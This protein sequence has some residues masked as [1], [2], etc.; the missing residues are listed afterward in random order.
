MTIIDNIFDD[1]DIKKQYDEIKHLNEVKKA[2]EIYLFH[3]YEK[4]NIILEIRN[5]YYDIVNRKQG[6]ITQDESKFQRFD[7][8]LLEYGGK[9]FDDKNMNYYFKRWTNKRLKRILKILNMELKNNGIFLNSK[10]NILEILK[11]LKE[12]FEMS[13]VENENESLNNLITLFNNLIRNLNE[14]LNYFQNIYPIKNW[15]LENHSSIIDNRI[16]NLISVEVKLVFDKNISSDYFNN[17]PGIISRAIHEMNIPTNTE[18]NKLINLHIQK[19]KSKKGNSKI[20]FV[21]CYHA[22]PIQILKPVFPLSTREKSTGFYVDLDM[23]EA[24]E[25]IKAI[26]GVNEAN[27]EVYELE[28][29]NNLF[30]LTN[31]DFMDDSAFKNFEMT[32]SYVFKPTTY[33]VINE[34]YIKGLIKVKKITKK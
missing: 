22:R 20:N 16:L 12:N 15:S 25:I 29:P 9:V 18:L 28:L 21:K 23:G 26:Y 5:K 4:I 27:I 3:I 32:N 6:F 33:P 24:I 17:L 10:K 14:Q 13:Y 2:F 8:S 7:L 31:N 19:V 30:K 11:D 1:E 34:S